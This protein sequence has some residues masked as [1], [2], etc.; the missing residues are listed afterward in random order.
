MSSRHGA[1]RQERSKAEVRKVQVGGIVEKWKA[2]A[3]LEPVKDSGN[4][5]VVPEIELEEVRFD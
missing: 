4:F 3:S 1:S 5:K 2:G